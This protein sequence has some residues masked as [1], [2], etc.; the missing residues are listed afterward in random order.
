MPE[1]TASQLLEAPAD[2]VWQLLEDFGAIQRWWPTDVSMP[3]ERV[4]VD[5]EGIGMIRRILNRGAAHTVDER[6][7][8]IDP[9]ERRLVLSIVGQRPAG[10]TAYLGEGRITEIDGNRCRMDYRALVTTSPGLEAAVSKA[11]QKTWALMFRGLESA[12]R[13]T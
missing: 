3:I 10:I 2:A 5:G 4:D 8:F 1:V 6:L 9:V 12:A 13:K 7:D 11:L